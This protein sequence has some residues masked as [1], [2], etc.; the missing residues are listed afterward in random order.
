MNAAL[1]AH[2]RGAEPQALPPPCYCL[3]PTLEIYLP[4]PLGIRSLHRPPAGKI[5]VM[6]GNPC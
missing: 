4:S 1:A 6:G 2:P 5:V 3:P